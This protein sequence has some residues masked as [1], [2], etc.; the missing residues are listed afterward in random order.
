MYTRILVP[1]DGSKLSERSLTEVKNIVAD[2]P[3]LEVMLL[4]VQEEII[5]FNSVPFV[6]SKAKEMVRQREKMNREVA[7][8]IDQYLSDKASGLSQEGITVKTEIIH[9]EPLK[10]VAEA[11]IDY[12]EANKADL[13][14]MTTRGQSGI[15]RWTMGTVADRVA[16]YS[17]VPV[18]IVPP[19]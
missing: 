11:I 1:L 14:V 19:E 6:E 5:P 13:I 10:S 8:K 16:R 15:K 2:Q 3:G 18:L 9:P 17:K 7:Q 4:M 12:A